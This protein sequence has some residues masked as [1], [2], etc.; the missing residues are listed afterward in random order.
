MG[1]IKGETHI[2]CDSEFKV[3]FRRHME[4]HGAGRALPDSL[5][6]TK[7]TYKNIALEIMKRHQFYVNL[8]KV[9]LWK[10][11]LKNKGG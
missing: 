11:N 4:P 7:C 8:V 2:H 3:D 5:Y 9:N 1:M 10:H 6:A